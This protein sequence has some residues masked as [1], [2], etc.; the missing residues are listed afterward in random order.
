MSHA[1]ARHSPPPMAAPLTAAITGWCILRMARITSSSTS[2]DRSANV[3]RVSPSTCGHRTSRLVV[4]TRG[5]P[6]AGAG[7]HDHAH[8]VVVGQLVERGLQRHHDVERHRVHPLGPVQ[9]HQ[10]H[11]RARTVDEDEGV[12]LL[13]HG[14]HAIACRPL[15]PRSA[16]ACRGDRGV[17]VEFLDLL[18]SGP[19][20]RRADSAPAWLKTMLALLEGHQRRDRPDVGGGGEF[21]LGLGVDLGVH[22]VG[23]LV[24]R[25]GERRREGATRSAPRRPEID[26]HDLVVVDGV[27]EL[28]RR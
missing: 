21:L 9:R 17:D 14:L 13:G 22:D 16:L 3:G 1:S 4:G 24:G 27:V 25:R 6:A 12:V 26:Q 15:T 11:V 18:R 28:A 20:G 7:Q 8:V 2:I 19:R 5:E 10:R 23:V